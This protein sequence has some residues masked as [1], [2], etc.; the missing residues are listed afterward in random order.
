MK[1]VVITG[2][3]SS[4]KSSLAH[5]LSTHYS[6]PLVKEYAREHLNL[7]GPNY[8]AED[9]EYMGVKQLTDIENCLAD[10]VVCDTD[11]LTYCIWYEVAY[12]KR[13]EILERA[14]KGFSPHCYL[15]LYP[16]LPWEP[17]PLREHPNQRIAL[18]ERYRDRLLDMKVPFREIRGVHRVDRCNKALKNLREMGFEP[19]L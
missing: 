2:P 11:V 9:V 7:H 5:F 17:D 16:D 19:I 6:I 12:G 10:A 14:L 15:L 1:K 8:T 13:S 4:G 3:E 18:F